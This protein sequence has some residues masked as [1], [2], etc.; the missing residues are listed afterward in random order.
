MRNTQSR[1]SWLRLHMVYQTSDSTQIHRDSDLGV[2]G[3][4]Q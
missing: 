4:F 1:S 3:M 2:I